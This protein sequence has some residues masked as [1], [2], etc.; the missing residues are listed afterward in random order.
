MSFLLDAANVSTEGNKIEVTG[1]LP[2]KVGNVSI[3]TIEQLFKQLYE[4]KANDWDM[5]T[6]YV[7]GISGE[8]GD[9]STIENLQAVGLDWYKQLNKQTEASQTCVETK[10]GWHYEPTTEVQPFVSNGKT[11]FGGPLHDVCYSQRNGFT[12]E[13]TAAESVIYQSS[14]WY[15]WNVMVNESIYVAVIRAHE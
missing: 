12:F 8:Y 1:K 10:Y 13:F 11:I 14:R 9:D 5:S 6:Y 4:N 7:Y 2:A 15:C 3:M